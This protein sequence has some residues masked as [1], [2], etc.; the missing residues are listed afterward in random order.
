M[1]GLSVTGTGSQQ[2][3]S[4]SLPTGSFLVQRNTPEQIFIALYCKAWYSRLVRRVA[5]LHIGLSLYILYS[6]FHFFTSLCFFLSAARAA[7]YP[8]SPHPWR[9]A[10][11]HLLFYLEA[12]SF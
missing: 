10:A 7:T 12:Q 2:K 9:V 3:P 11:R 1:Q 6:Y 5:V 4:L 8:G